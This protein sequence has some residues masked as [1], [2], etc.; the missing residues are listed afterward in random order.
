MGLED[1]VSDIKAVQIDDYVSGQ[2]LIDEHLL[3]SFVDY[4]EDQIK[5][6]IDIG[7]EMSGRLDPPF[8]PRQEH[9]PDHQIDRN[10]VRGL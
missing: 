7:E 5:K 4:H 10:I 2:T 6:D 8:D 1:K 9:N 3:Y